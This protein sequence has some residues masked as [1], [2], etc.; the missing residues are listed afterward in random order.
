MKLVFHFKHLDY[1]KSL[2]L[3]TQE[4]VDKVSYFLLKDEAGSVH[5][6]K[7]RNDFKVELSVPSRQ[8]FFKSEA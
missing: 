6:S 4:Q 2:E 7:F 1:S 5:F 8:R 3:Y